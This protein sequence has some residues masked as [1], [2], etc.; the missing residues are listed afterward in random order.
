MTHS[1]KET[2][3]LIVDDEPANIKVLMPVLVEQGY[4]VRTA[5][6]GRIA[7]S[8]AMKK[9]PALILLDVR[10]PDMDGFEVCRQ[11][12]AD[13]RVASV[14]IIFI[15]ALGQTQD[16]VQGLKLGG[17]DY[18]TKPFRMDEVLARIETHLQIQTLQWELKKSNDQLQ[19]EIEERKR[20][21]KKLRYLNEQ[22]E[23]RVAERTARL[24]KQ[25]KDLM[26]AKEAA[27][28]ATIA[29]SKFLSNLSHELRTPLNPI[30][31]YAQI[32]KTNK[33][34]T[35]EQKEQLQIICDSGMHLTS[36]I[37]DMLELVRIDTQL[38]VVECVDFN[39]QELL[40][41]LI[42]DTRKK[43]LKKNI[44]VRYEDMETI[45][46]MVCGD[47]RML[48]HVLLHLLDNAVKFTDTG[49]VTLRLSADR[50]PQ[51]EG[52]WQF[53]FE[54]LDTG[55]GIP[56][57]IMDKIFNPFFQ[58]E[59]EGRIIDGTGLGLS[60]CHRLVD[61]MGGC[62]TVQSPYPKE[63]KTEA[64]APGSLF[65]MKIDLEAVDGDKS[66]ASP[67][68]SESN[69]TQ[70]KRVLIVDDND[71]NLNL[72]VH[73]LAPLGFDITKAVCGKDALTSAHQKSPDLILLD[74]YMPG[75]DGD[76]VLA[77]IRSNVDMPQ[78]KVIGV[79]AAD[80]ND[81]RVM[82]FAAACDDYLEKPVSIDKLLKKIEQ[83]IGIG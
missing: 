41:G 30:M 55:I 58:G 64:S 26:E 3:I 14:P 20:A 28:A 32:L 77:N 12:K 51:S 80:N 78:V 43:A 70:Q 50:A 48:H 54:V 37:S 61:L 40:L 6:G 21:E 33:N 13:K 34:M 81:A 67:S 5:L 9:L 4:E 83:H 47:G 15:S 23:H 79:S 66:G 11:L 46:G 36:L 10:M 62:L 63:R 73:A 52:I 72:L 8:S 17:A 59:I 68:Q 2:N 42:L 16:I 38:E 65:T 45:P 75:M 44:E 27:E 31:G 19:T 60:L 1:R 57:E 35:N 49:S 76:E 24:Y 53:C 29:K 7:I 22:L 18:I 82:A 69:A 74:F 39:L 71:L 25:T 56:L